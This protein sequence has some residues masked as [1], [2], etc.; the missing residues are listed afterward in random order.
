MK[1]MRDE[2]ARRAP[3]MVRFLRFWFPIFLFAY[4]SFVQFVWVAMPVKGP[5]A[6]LGHV[7]PVPIGVMD[8]RHVIWY[9][10]V[11]R[12]ESWRKSFDS[13]SDDTITR[14]WVELR[15]VIN[16]F[17]K[18]MNVHDDKP[19]FAL[20]KSQDLIAVHELLTDA[21]FAAREKGEY[22]TFALERVEDMRSLIDVGI[23]FPDLALQY[24]DLAS[25]KT[26]GF[27]EF[28]EDDLPETYKEAIGQE[29]VTLV[30]T[31]THYV[32][33]E[34]ESVSEGVYEVIELGI[35][36]QGLGETFYA[37]LLEHS[38]KWF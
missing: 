6:L 1:V 25:A 17:A 33:V 14:A 12:V 16:S 27:V 34:V 37:Y 11:L 35:E 29:D 13:T 32:F 9:Q 26:K 20:G 10:D 7:V 18:E 30:E 23:Y 3:V 8:E 22:Q 2:R 21:A 38:I 15:E 19:F 24:S 31:A 5:L 4:M 36:K 28:D